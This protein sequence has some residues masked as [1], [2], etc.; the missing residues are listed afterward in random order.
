MP[1]C[2]VCGM[3]VDRTNPAETDYQ[4]EE[5]APATMEYEGETYYFCSTEHEEEFQNG[6]EKYVE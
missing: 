5:Y 6:P 4:D 3:E 2:P 1:T